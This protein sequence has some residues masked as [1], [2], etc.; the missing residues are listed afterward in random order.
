VR[1]ERLACALSQCD[2]VS[3]ALAL[4]VSLQVLNAALGAFTWNVCMCQVALSAHR[5]AACSKLTGEVLCTVRPFVAI[6]GAHR[7]YGWPAMAP[8]A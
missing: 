6:V 8:S 1:S 4:V 3:A 2:K 5:S 7:R